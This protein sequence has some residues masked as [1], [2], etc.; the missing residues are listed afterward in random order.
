[1]QNKIQFILG[2]TIALT[3]LGLYVYTL[4]RMGLSVLEYCNDRPD[5]TP[6]NYKGPASLFNYIATTIGGL[7]SA[8]VIA[9]LGASKAGGND[10]FMLMEGDKVKLPRL[11]M[12]LTITYLVVWIIMGVFSLYVGGL[13]YPEINPHVTNFG[14]LW[15]GLAVSAAYAYFQISEKPSDT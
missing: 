10:R 15:L 3:L 8:L 5:C 13:K 14:M 9:Y 12:V 2:G 7:I 6:E 11:T 1:M 4:G